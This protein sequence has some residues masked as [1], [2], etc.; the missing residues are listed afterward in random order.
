MS[1]PRDGI[2][3][4]AGRLLFDLLEQTEPVL[5]SL[6][7]RDHFPVVGQELVKNGLLQPWGSELADVVGDLADDRPVSV[8]PS[9]DGK[10]LGFFSE[11]SGWVSVPTEGLGRYRV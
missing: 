7:L 9:P 10:G 11:A 8:L 4:R 1:A 2:S 3:R 6:A 5:S